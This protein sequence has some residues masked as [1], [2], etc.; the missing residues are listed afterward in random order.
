MITPDIKYAFYDHSW[1][2]FQSYTNILHIL[3]LFFMTYWFIFTCLKYFITCEAASAC[4]SNCSRSRGSTRMWSAVSFPS[5]MSS[6]NTIVTTRPCSCF[7]GKNP[8][9]VEMFRLQA[10]EEDLRYNVSHYVEITT[11]WS[12]VCFYNQTVPIIIF[13]H[14]D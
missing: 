3:Y 6:S 2:K 8:K 7:R 1:Y 14:E 13:E 4:E 12:F 11:H 5:E 9:M 10:T